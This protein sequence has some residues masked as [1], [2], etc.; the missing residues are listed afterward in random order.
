MRTFEYAKRHCEIFFPL[1]QY[2]CHIWIQLYFAL[3]AVSY[4]SRFQK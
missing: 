4:L 3:F 1:G 2:F